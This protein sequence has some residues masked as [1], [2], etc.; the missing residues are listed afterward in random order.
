MCRFN[1]IDLCGNDVRPRRVCLI[2]VLEGFLPN[3]DTLMV[4]TLAAK[5]EAIADMLVAYSGT[6]FS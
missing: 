3:S 4:V 1:L 5:A 6:V 2:Q